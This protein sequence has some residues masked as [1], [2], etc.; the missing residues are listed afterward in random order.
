M[1]KPT[2]KGSHLSKNSS[3]E[4]PDR[5]SLTQNPFAL[6]D[7]DF[8]ADAG[9]SVPGSWFFMIRVWCLVFRSS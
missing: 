4:G 2:D 6:K 9:D 5:D 1:R 7:A 3:R 8:G